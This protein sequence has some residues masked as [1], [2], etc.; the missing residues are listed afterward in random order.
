MSSD[1][2]SSDNE[3]N[4]FV[5]RLEGQY[6]TIATICNNMNSGETQNIMDSITLLLRQTNSSIDSSFLSRMLSVPIFSQNLEIQIRALSALSLLLRPIPE[7]I[8]L[9]TPFFQKAMS[10]PKL[11]PYVLQCLTYLPS[12]QLMKQLRSSINNAANSSDPFICKLTLH[13]LFSVYKFSKV[14]TNCELSYYIISLARRFLFQYQI[15]TSALSVLSE[16]AFDE[17]K[18]LISLAPLLILVFPSTIKCIQSFSDLCKI[19]YF[20]APVLDETNSSITSQ[21]IIS[22]LLSALDTEPPFP[23]IPPIARLCTHL[24]NPEHLANITGQWLEQCCLYTSNSSYFYTILL[25]LHQLLPWHKPNVRII[26]RL[27]MSYDPMVRA[28]AYKMFL[29]PPE[30]LKKAVA[31]L[32]TVNGIINQPF[33]ISMA[34][35]LAPKKGAWFVSL[36]FSIHDMKAKLGPSLLADTIRNLDDIQTISLLVSESKEYLIE[37]P[38][39][40]F[41]IALA[42]LISEQS[43]NPQ[44]VFFLLPFDISAKSKKFQSAALD[45]AIDFYRRE[46][47]DIDLNLMNRIKLLCFST[48]RGIRQRAAQLLDMGGKSQIN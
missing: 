19:F 45:A 29:P 15:L 42:E 41:G 11:L 46:K 18:S 48:N 28:M 2:E 3:F 21:E 25:G 30:K 32:L 26:L 8:K 4:P 1:S 24:K 33:L 44:D 17:P 22:S 43:N 40:D 9:F 23:F 27:E 20:L 31:D 6:K 7:N 12:Y 16:I 14:D 5:E 34:L 10:F 37:L 39:D 47:F 36:L 35:E 13:Y 38:D